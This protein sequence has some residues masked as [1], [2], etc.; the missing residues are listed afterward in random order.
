MSKERLK[1][2]LLNAFYITIFFLF[3]FP[4]FEYSLDK[5]TIMFDDLIAKFVFFF[6][7]NFIWQYFVYKQYSKLQKQKDELSKPKQF[8]CFKCGH[9]VQPNERKCPNCGWTWQ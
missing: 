2:S 9:V 7:F 8:N 5:K 1:F 3:G 6:I 4:L